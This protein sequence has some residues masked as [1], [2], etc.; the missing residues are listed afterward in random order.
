MP[1]T[2]TSTT[3][4]AKASRRHRGRTLDV[5]AASAAVRLSG[6]IPPPPARAQGSLGPLAQIPTA[7]P[8]TAAP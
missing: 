6:L 5:R 2:T 1:E 8:L 4:D 7:R 3:A